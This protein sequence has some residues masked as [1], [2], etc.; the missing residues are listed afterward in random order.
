MP[1]NSPKPIPNLYDV[2]MLI[3]PEKLA[4]DNPPSFNENEQRLYDL[5][6]ELVRNLA[7]FGFSPDIVQKSLLAELGNDDYPS[8]HFMTDP[9]VSL[10]VSNILTDAL[11]KVYGGSFR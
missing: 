3:Q 6:C 11:A 5:L 10:R 4:I 9:L 1:E 2:S 7:V 8:S